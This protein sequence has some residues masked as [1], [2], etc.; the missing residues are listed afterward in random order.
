[1]YLLLAGDSTGPARLAPVPPPELNDGPHLN[2]AIQWFG[3]ALA[4]YNVFRWWIRRSYLERQRGQ[5]AA[6]WQRQRRR[7][8]RRTYK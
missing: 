7:K 6:E 1:M 5:Q 3:I 8:Q 2:Y 4:G